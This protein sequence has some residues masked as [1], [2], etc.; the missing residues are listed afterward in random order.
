M[1][2]AESI[3]EASFLSEDLK[4]GR[5]AFIEKRRPNFRGK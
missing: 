2:T 5:L 4:E 3:A 1:R